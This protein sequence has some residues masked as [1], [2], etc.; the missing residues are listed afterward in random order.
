MLCIAHK[1]KDIKSPYCPILIH[2]FLDASLL[3][4]GKPG[5]LRDTNGH[6]KYG[7]AY[8]SPDDIFIHMKKLSD[9]SNP[10]VKH[11]IFE[12]IHPFCDVNGRTGRIILL[13]DLD[14]DI[15]QINNFCDRNYFKRIENA[16]DKY[17]NIKKLLG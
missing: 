8:S 12:L 6:S 5:M 11:I 15:N 7:N 10:F 1:L 16:I 9:I 13:S 17:G 2:K 3:K 4:K 14:Y